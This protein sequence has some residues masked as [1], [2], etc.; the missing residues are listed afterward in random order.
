[1]LARQ[2]ARC[3]AVAAAA[4]LPAPPAP[5][6]AGA[7]TASTCPSSTCAPWKLCS[8]AT[9][10]AQGARTAAGSQGR[11]GGPG[12]GRRRPAGAHRDAGH[13]P[14][15]PSPRQPRPAVQPHTLGPNPQ[16]PTHPTDSF[17]GLPPQLR[18][19][20]KPRRI[21]HA[22]SA[23]QPTCMLHLHGLHHHQRVALPHR[24]PLTHK[25]L[26]ARLARQRRARVGRGVGARTAGW[27]G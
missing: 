6:A 10:P 18:C 27:L 19:L 15:P 13:P 16:Q 1:M 9:V 12:C 23:P 20:R 7:T 11:A 14:S 24:C 22:S 26:Q 21:R 5:A 17:A 3:H 4:S 2:R 8:S 25:H